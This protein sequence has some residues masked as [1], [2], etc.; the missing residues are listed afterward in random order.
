MNRTC[1]LLRNQ[2]VL[3]ITTPAGKPRRLKSGEMSREPRHIS[4]YLVTDLRPDKRVADPAF[5]L[6]KLNGDGEAWD[7]HVDAHGASCSCPDV[8]WRG[9]HKEACK[10]VLACRAVGL[11]P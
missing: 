3:V 1:K 11:I 10:H 2:D 7:V 9:N 6:T 8:D 4:V 5:R